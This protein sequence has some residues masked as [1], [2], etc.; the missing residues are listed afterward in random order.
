MAEN[1]D[2]SSR[3]SDNISETSESKL[4][5]ILRKQKRCELMLEKNE[6][7]KCVKFPTR[8]IF[9]GNHGLI[10]GIGCEELI[11]AFEPFGKIEDIILPQNK[12]YSFI[13]YTKSEEAEMAMRNLQGVKLEHMKQPLY[14]SFADKVP[15]NQKLFKNENF[16]PGL[17]L[18]KDFFTEQQEEKILQCIKWDDSVYGTC[19]YSGLHMLCLLSL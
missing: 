6:N 13:V 19:K 8:F 7:V 3:G 17:I 12:S 10:C 5:K 2:T 11:T 14:L 9:V 1:V 15:S 18:I 4:K 16:P